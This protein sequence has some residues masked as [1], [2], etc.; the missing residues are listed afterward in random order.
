MPDCPG[1][2]K[3]WCTG[4]GEP[5]APW[6]FIFGGSLSHCGWKCIWCCSKN[7]SL[8]FF[9]GRTWGLVTRMPSVFSKR[10]F[11]LSE[12]ETPT[13]EQPGF[14]DPKPDKGI[15][16]TSEHNVTHHRGVSWAGTFLLPGSWKREVNDDTSGRFY[17]FPASMHIYCDWTPFL[18]DKLHP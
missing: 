18:L 3:R 14:L 1:F 4:G 7:L 8:N 16:N 6:S 11:F 17:H 12:T 9:P 2:T 10:L 15:C 5:K 13:G